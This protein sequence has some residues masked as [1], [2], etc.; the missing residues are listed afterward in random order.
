M[1]VLAHNWE[2]FSTS[3]FCFLPHFS[4]DLPHW[5]RQCNSADFCP[6]QQKK[7]I[8]IFPFEQTIYKQ[9]WA[10]P[11][12]LCL[13]ISCKGFYMC[14]HCVLCSA[15]VELFYF[16]FRLSFDRSKLII[17]AV[18]AHKLK[19]TGRS[20]SSCAYTYTYAHIDHMHQTR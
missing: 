8:K 7:W 19:F 9:P 18:C 10:L 16:I 14:A 5:I 1:R 13:L 2:Y 6:T 11:M 17:N 12:C 20:A 3:Y 15:S 4:V